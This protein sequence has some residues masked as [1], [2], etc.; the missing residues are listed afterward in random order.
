GP[1]LA[2][3]H[4]AIDGGRTVL[5]RRARGR[6]GVAGRGGE[7]GHVG[8]AGTG[9]GG[10]AKPRLA[11]RRAVGI[12]RHA[13]PPAD[14]RAGRGDPRSVVRVHRDR[15]WLVG[16]APPRSRLAAPRPGVLRRT[17]RSSHPYD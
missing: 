9:D 13:A 7:V 6:L 3:R 14:R 17:R 12:E 16:E 8:L 4:A 15:G 2:D 5:D 11:V 1:A 10:T